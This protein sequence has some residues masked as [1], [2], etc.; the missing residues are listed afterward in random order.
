[1]RRLADEGITV[2]LS[3]HLLTE[4]E[5]LCN[6]VAIIRK[7]RIV[8]EGVLTELLAT[9][10]EHVPAPR[11]RAGARPA[12]AASPSPGSRTSQLDGG[13]I[14]FRPSEDAVA[15]CSRSRSARPGSA[16]P[17]SCPSCDSLEELFLGMTEGDPGDA[18]TVQEA[19]AVMRGVATVYRWELAKLAAQKR[20][21][22]GL[23]AA[24]ARADRV[25]GRARCPE[26]RRADRR[27]ARADTLRDTGLATPFVVLF[28]MS[29]WGL[30]LI[31]ALVAGDI[32][33]SESHNGTLK[34]ILTRSRDRGEIFA[35]KMLATLTYTA[36]AVFAMAAVGLVG[37]QD[38]VGLAS[39][40][41]R[42]R[43]RPCPSATASC[44]SARASASTR[45]RSPASRRSGSCSRR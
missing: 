3:S 15:R 14:V 7:G 34:T 42:S 2:L 9:A 29:I 26:G 22:L 20:T 43:A 31:T 11:P 28:F 35:G 32:V 37:R 12:R 17:R 38:R 45:S 1:M 40:R 30:P 44:C 33:A 13:E 23:G 39:A 10:S 25:R 21:Y 5:E 41:R 36:A 8:Y 16:S 4:V 24:V 6:R 27:A 18:S 19:A